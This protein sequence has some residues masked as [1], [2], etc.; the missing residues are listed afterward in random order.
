MWNLFKQKE[1]DV[2]EVGWVG[3]S[4]MFPLPVLFPPEPF[5]YETNQKAPDFLRCPSVQDYLTNLYVIRTPLDFSVSM[6]PGNQVLIETDPP[7]YASSIANNLLYDARIKGMHMVQMPMDIGFVSD[8]PDVILELVAIPLGRYVGHSF[9][10][11][12]LNIYDWP[13]RSLS[14]SFEWY[15]STIPVKYKRGDAVFCIRLSHPSGKKIVLKQA[16]MTENIR[17]V[18]YDINVIKQGFTHGTRGMIK[19]YSKLRR[20]KLLEWP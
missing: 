17:K 3:L 11:G 10:V 1:P 19:N 18:L 2:I 7:Q 12:R 13:A 6:A 15:D 9:V 14:M 20:T 4:S 8:T 16:V 5:R